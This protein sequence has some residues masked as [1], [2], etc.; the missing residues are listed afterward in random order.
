M[1][2]YMDRDIGLCMNTLKVPALTK[3]RNLQYFLKAA[4]G[5][6]AAANGNSAAAATAAASGAV[7]GG[8]IVTTVGSAAEH[9]LTRDNIAATVQY[10]VV[11]GSAMQSLLNLMDGVFRR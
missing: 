4:P 3:V 1:V 7:G 2:V 9:V 10:G 8:G 5:D 6:A 11:S